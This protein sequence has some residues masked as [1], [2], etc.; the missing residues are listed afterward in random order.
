MVYGEK[1]NVMG[2]WEKNNE[3][4]F[5]FLAYRDETCSN[6][7]ARDYISKRGW[8]LLVT[9]LETLMWNIFEFGI[10][11]WD[12]NVDDKLIRIWQPWMKIKREW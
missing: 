9:D 2:Y 10:R 8:F 5:N 6:I 1:T 12:S 11:G 7:D 3:H 4:S